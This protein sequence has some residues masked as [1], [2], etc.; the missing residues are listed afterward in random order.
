M[1]PLVWP[2]NASLV[3]LCLKEQAL[4]LHGSISGIRCGASNVHH[5]I[6]HANPA[7]CRRL[8][9]MLDEVPAMPIP[10]VDMWLTPAFRAYIVS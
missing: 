5:R 2:S 10:K 4:E 7:A 8:P 6:G 9:V 1:Q 3:L